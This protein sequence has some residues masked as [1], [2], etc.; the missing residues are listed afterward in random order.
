MVASSLRGGTMAARSS[1]TKLYFPGLGGIYDGL[2]DW[3]YPLL[4]ITAGLML[5]PHAW[6]K[7]TT[8]GAAGVAAGLA[9]RGIEPA[10][11]FA[12][13][14][15]FVELVGGICIAIGFLTRPF[16]LLCLIEMIVIAVKAHL[17]NGWF[18]SVQGGGGE[19][20]V[21]WA[22]LF[23]IILIRGGGHFSVDRAIGK[24]V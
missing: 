21:M 22:I 16:A 10:L 24:E 18:F 13:L 4:R 17:P 12:Y 23:L 11:A 2:A 19:F 9:R 7:F 5:I 8:A 15:M 20:P 1:D 3:G 6:P 14:I